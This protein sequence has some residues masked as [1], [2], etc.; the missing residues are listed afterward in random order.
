MNR[1]SLTRKI[2]KRHLKVIP[3]K[4]LGTICNRPIWDLCKEYINGLK[5]N[6]RFTRTDFL[7]NIY[8]EKPYK[9]NAADKYRRAL[10]ILGILEHVNTGVYM[11][12]H[13]IPKH[14]TV[15]QLTNAAY[16]DSWKTW[17]IP[18]E[19]KFPKE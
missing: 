12:K 13:N 16:D 6:E 10:T 7:C 5:S 8:R 15:T 18:L 4:N 1:R 11:K 9:E 17:F 14:A 2:K 19:N 3:P